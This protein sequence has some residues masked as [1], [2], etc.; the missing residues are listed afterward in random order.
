MHVGFMI[1]SV[2]I[3]EVK[4]ILKALKS[5]IC[6]IREFDMQYLETETWIMAEFMKIWFVLNCCVEDMMFM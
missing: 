1:L 5:F 4:N 3:F 6:V 2:T